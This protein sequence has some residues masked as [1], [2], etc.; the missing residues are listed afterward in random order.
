MPLYGRSAPRLQTL[1]EAQANHRDKIIDARGQRAG[2]P[3]STGPNSWFTPSSLLVDGGA[4][5]A[6][7]GASP[8]RQSGLQSGSR[9]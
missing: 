3:P 6:A 7:S 4:A 2:L 9:G 5:L 1:L 8:Y